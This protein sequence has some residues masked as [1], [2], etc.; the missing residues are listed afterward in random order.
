MDTSETAC[1][2]FH[3]V[4]DTDV[5]IAVLAPDKITGIEFSDGV[6]VDISMYGETIDGVHVSNHPDI[7][8]V[9]NTYTNIYFTSRISPLGL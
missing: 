2:Y 1:R 3:T 4:V 7:A 5:A 9:L 6:V 8:E